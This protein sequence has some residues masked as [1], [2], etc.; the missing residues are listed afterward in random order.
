[1]VGKVGKMELA[2]GI[3]EAK[4]INCFKGEKIHY[5][6]YFIEVEK[7]SSN[8]KSKEMA[9]CKRQKGFSLEMTLVDF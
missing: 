7:Q 1:M 6:K 9:S 3:L 4:E 5:V 8:D 2:C